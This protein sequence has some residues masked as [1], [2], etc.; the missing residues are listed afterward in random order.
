[1]ADDST[2]S[3][4]RPYGGLRWRNIG[5]HRG[6][7]CVAV[8]G[9]P[10]DRAVFFMG[11]TGGGVWRSTNAG[12]TWQNL[13][14]GQVGSASVGALAVAASDPSIVY[15]GM[16]ESCIRGNVGVGDG[17]YRSLDGGRTWSHLGLAATEH[18]ARVRVHPSRPDL[19]Y[20][21]ALGHAFGPNAERGVYRS[22]DGGEHFERVLFRDE[23]TG[24]ID[25][26]MDPKSPSVLY[27]AL[28]QGRRAPWRMMSGGPGSGIFRS[29]DGGSTQ[30]RLRRQLAKGEQRERA[31]FAPLVL[32][33]RIRRPQGRRDRIL[34]RHELPPL[35][36]WRPHVSHDRH[37]A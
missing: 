24:A 16:G 17:V 29:L 18:I 33:P 30:R 14:D 32:H 8:V 9:H 23:D 31:A 20:V 11:T 25:L 10:A 21:A 26:S 34:P 6:G 28:W 5:P 3:S 36:G 35:T 27:A 12:V 4:D 15:V 2:A 7:R 22:K 13:T 1:M 37:A 19:V